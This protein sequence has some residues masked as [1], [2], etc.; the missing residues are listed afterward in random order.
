MGVG[1]DG[2][3]SAGD[4]GAGKAKASRKGAKSIFASVPRPAERLYLEN[5]RQILQDIW[6]QASPPP[7]VGPL[8]E[9]PLRLY[10]MG[11][12]TVDPPTA[13]AND[14]NCLGSGAN[15]QTAVLGEQSMPRINMLNIY[16]RCGEI[17]DA[18]YILGK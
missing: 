10:P 1:V 5:A 4:G 9:H 8:E 3:S 7:T 12:I 16:K 11:L 2:D 14:T 13:E 17:G 15:G 18:L 6:N